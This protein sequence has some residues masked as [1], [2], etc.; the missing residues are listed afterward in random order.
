MLLL[1]L[2]QEESEVPD[3]ETVNQMI[4]RTEEEFEIYQVYFSF[5]LILI[6]KNFSYEEKSKKKSF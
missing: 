2:S 4:A 3:D 5:T 1:I 6:K